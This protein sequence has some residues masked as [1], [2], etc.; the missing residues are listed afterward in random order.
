MKPA[1]SKA[2][3]F[4][5]P[6]ITAFAPA[7][8]A[9]VAVGFDILGFAMPV[10]GDRVTV[11]VVPG[12]REIEI[13]SITGVVTELPRDA[14][15][16]TATVA[17]QTLIDEHGLKHGFRVSIE[18]GITMGSGM[19]G[20]AASAVGAVVAGAH[21]S[22]LSLTREQ[23]LKCAL[24]GE[25]VASGAVHADN[26]APCLYGGLTLAISTDPV[27]IV[28]IPTPPEL[29]CVL[30]HPHLKVETRHARSILKPQILLR[31]HVLQSAHLAGLITGCH[32]GDIEL[33]RSTLIDIL[34]E[35][36][37]SVLI[38]GFD[39]AKVQAID[40]GAL[41]FS[42]SGSGPSV[43]AWTSSRNAAERV[44]IAI[45]R[46]FEHHKIAADAWIGPVGGAG[47]HVIG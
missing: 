45:V 38:P 25:A 14:A 36:Q 23:L 34:I 17:L 10:V 22:G 44:K 9:N 35:P 4:A 3:A 8:V 30:V 43:F 21:A 18:K 41:G 39:D 28:R 16:N 7:T 26:V 20:S 47:A 33:I 11:E 19:G 42:I 2:T 12:S 24:D 27:R 32:Q 6:K 31:E 37:R 29:L 46:A 1:P 15:K 40:Q 13:T 5:H